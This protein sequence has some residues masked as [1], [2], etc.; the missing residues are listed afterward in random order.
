MDKIN[1]QASTLNADSRA[2]MSKHMRNITF[3]QQTSLDTINL[4]SSS[5]S[6]YLENLPKSG[7]LIDSRNAVQDLK[8]QTMSIEE[9]GDDDKRQ[10]FPNIYKTIDLDSKETVISP[11]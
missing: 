10:F 6:Q 8:N 4:M 9:E 5:D 7:H 2:D 1:E 3:Q 11:S